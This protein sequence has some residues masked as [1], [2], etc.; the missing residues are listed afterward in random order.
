MNR[1]PQM[2]KKGLKGSFPSGS[3]GSLNTGLSSRMA[4]GSETS[5]TDRR[6]PAQMPAPATTVPFKG[7]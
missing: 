7:K 1:N 5:M 6:G 2:K 3:G 4:M